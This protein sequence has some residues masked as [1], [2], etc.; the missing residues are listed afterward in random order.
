MFLTDRTARS[1][2]GYWHDNVVCQLS[3]CLSV[4]PSDCNSVSALRLNDTTYSK[5]V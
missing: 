5:S 3:V 4:R 2:I 1:T